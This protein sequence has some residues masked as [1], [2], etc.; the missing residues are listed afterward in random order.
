MMMICDRRNNVVISAAPAKRSILADSVSLDP[1]ST[2]STCR[3][4][5]I[6]RFID[7]DLAGSTKHCFLPL[8]LRAITLTLED[9][10]YIVRST[11]YIYI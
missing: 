10:G 7:S 6:Y 8:K 9:T 1:F 2:Q 11:E 3:Y 4:K 5:R